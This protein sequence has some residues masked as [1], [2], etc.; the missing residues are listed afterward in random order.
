MDG[1]PALVSRTTTGQVWAGALAVESAPAP[2]SRS[3]T[4]RSRIRPTRPSRSSTS[5]RGIRA[6][7]RSRWRCPTWRPPSARAG[8]KSTTRRWARPAS[9]SC[10]S[11]SG[12]MRMSPTRPRRAGAATGSAIAV[13][14]GRRF[15]GHLA[16][17]VGHARGRGRVRRWPT[18]PWSV[19]CPSRPW[20]ARSGMTRCWWSMRRTRSCCAERRRRRLR[21]GGIRGATSSRGRRSRAA[22]GRWRARCASRRPG[23]GAP[24]SERASSVSTLQSR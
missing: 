3:S 23:P 4:R 9:A 2:T 5:T 6:R 21:P 1:R 17:G 11:T 7:P 14:P 10:S 24:R 15:R 8:R 13:G 19:S 22:R 18:R 12:W 20:S 16:A